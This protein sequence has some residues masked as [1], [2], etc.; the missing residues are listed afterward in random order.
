MRLAEQAL[1]EE[2]TRP[3]ALIARAVGYTSES[4]FD[5]A[6]RR[7]TGVWLKA[8]RGKGMVGVRRLAD[9]A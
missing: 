3:V 8:H 7:T 4:A 1:R 9:T 5:N 6:F 2:R